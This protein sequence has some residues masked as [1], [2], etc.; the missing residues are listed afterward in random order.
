MKNPFKKAASAIIGSFTQWIK[1]W[2]CNAPQLAT[3]QCTNVNI[4]R[5]HTCK[6]G[7]NMS[8]KNWE[9]VNHIR[10]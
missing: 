10:K 6:C 5:K 1:C 7:A 4:I 9:I 3:V 8:T 2:K